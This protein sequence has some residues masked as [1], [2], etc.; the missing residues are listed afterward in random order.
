MK[1]SSVCKNSK[2]AKNSK[3][4]ITD[5]YG[6]V[7]TPRAIHTSEINQIENNFRFRCTLIIFFDFKSKVL[8]I[9]NFTHFIYFVLVCKLTLL[10]R[11]FYFY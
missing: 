1:I 10:Q 5:R 6:V 4:E 3:N 9:Y 2:A 7:T 8:T 11:F